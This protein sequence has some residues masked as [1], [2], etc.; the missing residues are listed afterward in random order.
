MKIKETII[1]YLKEHPGQTYTVAALAVHL[2][3]DAARDFKG[4]VKTL[5]ALEAEHQIHFTKAGAVELEQAKAP[6]ALVNGIFHANAN[7]FGFVT[8]DPDEDDVFIGKGQTKFALDGDEVQ[9]ELTKNANPLK[10]QSAEGH[11]EKILQHELHQ[12]VG[13][14]VAFT[15]EEAAETDLIGYVTSRNKKIPYRVYLT[16]KGL[17][18]EDKAVVRVEIT[19]Y[20]DA[21]FPDSMQGVATEIIG[22]KGDTGIDVLEVLASMDIRTIFPAEVLAQANAV[23]DQVS[24]SDLM[25]R[26]DYRDE[27]TFTIDGADAKD[28]DDAVHAKRLASGN[29]ELGVH[30]AD[31]SHYV[32]ENSP[33]DKE[34]YERGTSVYVTDRVVPML[35]ERLSNGICSLNPRVDRLTQSCVMEITPQGKVVNYQISQSVIKT[36]ERMTYDDVN[37]MIA[38]DEEALE[39]YAA[40]ADSV[41]IMTELHKIL[42]NMRT[43]RGTINFDTV[44]A[45]IIVDEKGLP[46]EIRKRQRGIAERMIESFM[47]AANETVASSFEKRNLPFI[48][49]IHEQ[50]KEDRL[51]RFLDF[52]ATFGIQVHGTAKNMSQ[53]ALQDFLN[54]VHG[55]PAE[56]VLSTMLLRSMQQARYSETNMGHFGIA[57]ENYTHFTSPIRRYPDLLVHRL[58]RE[59]EHPT[60]D[61]VNKWEEKIPEIAQHTSNRERRA[62]DA[63]REVEKMKKAEFMQEHVG[64]EQIGVI[65]SVTRFGLFVELENTVEGLIHI[66][67]FKNDFM[68]FQERTLS[69]V[70]ERSGKVYKIGQKIKVKIVNANPITGDI[71]FEYLPS[72]LDLIEKNTHTK[73]K[74]RHKKDKHSKAGENSERNHKKSK[75]KEW[76][77]E[78]TQKGPAKFSKQSKKKKLTETPTKSKKDS[79][80]K[81]SPKKEK[82]PQDQLKAGKNDFKKG[83]SKHARQKSQADLANEK[84]KK[85]SKKKAKKP[86]IAH[87]YTI[88]HRKD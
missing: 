47:L 78:R 43:K 67:T 22:H 10:T 80:K 86:Q 48:Y 30:I 32:T 45:K 72:D 76:A 87:P 13:T 20:P 11:V 31:V 53:Q 23:P 2:K 71:D 57:A 60:T 38:G 68:T 42:E 3:L 25:G 39:K 7:G 61:K 26:T 69:L 34:A 58:I 81:H 74:P 82:Q 36:T 66:S 79:A 4:F 59:M 85:N 73:H 35:P 8:I 15:K 70:G 64:E 41:Q 40:I 44:E 29:F 63:E 19:H 17:I 83:K 88:K 62:I 5:A 54:K 56:P 37:L 27:I 75:N 65:A 84:N 16:K 1:N 52:A 6:Q 33:L 24:P 77:N 21:E 18:P 14:F 9:I 49:R 12:L 55:T 51:Q 46:I 28:L 50:P